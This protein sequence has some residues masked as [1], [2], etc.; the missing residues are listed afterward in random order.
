MPLYNGTFDESGHRYRRGIE[1]LRSAAAV[2]LSRCSGV[3]TQHLRSKDVLAMVAVTLGFVFLFIAIAGGLRS[4]EVGLQNTQKIY[5]HNPWLCA[6]ISYAVALIGFSIFLAVAAVVSDPPWPTWADVRN[7]P[8]WA[9]FGG[10]VGGVAV[11]GMITVARYVG[12][13]TFNAVVITSEML[14]ALVMD[15]LG[16]M[17]FAA[18]EVTPLR[19]VAAGLITGAVVL[20]ARSSTKPV[21]VPERDAI[22]EEAL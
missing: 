10:L 6:V 2:R 19:L 11:V 1:V 14:V 22:L 12:I 5:I 16:L 13:A 7:M 4:V 8:W 9:P 3:V 20:M 18:R 17:G 15:D 21:S